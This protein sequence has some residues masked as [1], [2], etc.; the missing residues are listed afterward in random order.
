MYCVHE[1]RQPGTGRVDTRKHRNYILP[2]FLAPTVSPHDP[3]CQGRMD[4][5]EPS[6]PM[7]TQYHRVKKEYPHALV[8][9]RLGDFYELFFE[10]AVV[11][12]RELEITLT[13]RNK[14]KGLSVPMC[15]VPYHAADSYMAKLVRKGYKIAVC[16]QVERPKPSQK[17]VRREVSR[18][19]TPGTVADGNLL[20]P[21]EN[22][23]LSALW[24][25]RSGVGLASLDISTGDFQTTEFKG[26]N[27]LNS[28]RPS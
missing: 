20:E 6:T 10:D 24:V 13:S 17:L 15:G 1:A 5:M 23:F 22:N 2:G 9:F 7:M 12:S 27:A 21:Q 8:F 3:S 14:E 19:L 16:D 26:E 28:F 18:V 25:D 4:S 11:A